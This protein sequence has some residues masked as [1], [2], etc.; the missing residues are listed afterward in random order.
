MLHKGQTKPVDRP[1]QFAA[2]GIR[3]KRGG[4]TLAPFAAVLAIKGSYRKLWLIATAVM[5]LANSAQ[6]RLVGECFDLAEATDHSEWQMH[7]LRVALFWLIQSERSRL[8]APSSS[9][10]PKHRWP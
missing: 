10:E 8:I 7:C 5:I 2:L 6:I 1:V 4:E 9:A 3:Y